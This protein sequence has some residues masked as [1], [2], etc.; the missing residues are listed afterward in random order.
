[1]IR[2]GLFIA[3][4]PSDAPL[5]E[6]LA[7]LCA[8]RGVEVQ[9]ATPDLRRLPN[10]PGLSVTERLTAAFKIEG[11][12]EI[13]FVHRDAEKQTPKL[14]YEEIREAVNKIRPGLPSVAV[15]P[16]RMTEAWLLLDEEPIREIAGKPSGIT[17]L[18]LPPISKVED[19]PDPKETLRKAL[20][21]A[22]GLTGRRMK[23]F[24]RRFGENRRLL[25]QRLDVHG[26]V[27]QLSSWQALERS[28]DD[29]LS[30]LADGH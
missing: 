25:L 26:S 18:S 11:D 28:L 13:I 22:S 19:L 27:T 23:Q 20:E 12:Y 17:A 7:Y 9:I 30:T 10:P 29:V 2:R 4:G 6:H 3:D 21:M 24:Q 1:M 8:Q 16:I 15:V 5:G 14:R